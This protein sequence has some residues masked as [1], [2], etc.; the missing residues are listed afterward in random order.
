MSEYDHRDGGQ[1]MGARANDVQTLEQLNRSYVRAGQASDTRWFDEHLAACFM[2]SNPDGSLVDRAGFLDRIGRPNPSKNMAP[3]DTHIRVVG[4]VGLVDSGYQYT[5]P[6]GQDGVGHYTDVY[7][8]LEGRWQCVSAHFALRPAPPQ[9][10]ATK[11]ADV[12]AAAPNPTDHAGL[13]ELNHHYIRSVQESDVRWFDANLAPEFVNGNADGSFSDRA[14]FLT[15]IGKPSP[16][17]NLRVEDVRIQVVSDIGI[18]HARTAYTKPDGQ[19]GTGRYTDIWWRADGRW[20][21]VSAHV[22]RG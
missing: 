21:C 6:D 8:F 4:D 16:V 3:V 5:R 2:A 1:A 17:S 19:A 22:T 15:A 10:G 14:A 18:I 11:T 12:V 7:G 9:I 20:R 13:A